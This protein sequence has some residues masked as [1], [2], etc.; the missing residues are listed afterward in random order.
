[1]EKLS[2]TNHDLL[3]EMEGINGLAGEM[4]E[5]FVRICSGNPEIFVKHLSVLTVNGFNPAVDPYNHFLRHADVSSLST[6][7]ILF[8]HFYFLQFFLES[9]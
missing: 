6:L 1:M 2:L 4:R 5:A 9:L 3:N 8:L 7:F